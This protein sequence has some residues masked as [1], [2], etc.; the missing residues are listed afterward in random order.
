MNGTQDPQ[1]PLTENELTEVA[2]LFEEVHRLLREMEVKQYSEAIVAKVEATAEALQSTNDLSNVS[3]QA[4]DSILKLLTMRGHL[5]GAP[6]I[7][8]EFSKWPSGAQTISRC[9]KFAAARHCNR[10]QN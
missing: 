6:S 4:V 7:Q 5:P 3:P 2:E 9:N 1:I 10:R 8:E